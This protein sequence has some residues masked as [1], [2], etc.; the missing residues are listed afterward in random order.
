MLPVISGPQ[1]A[2][3]PKLAL[4]KNKPRTLPGLRFILLEKRLISSEPR[5][6]PRN[7]RS[8]S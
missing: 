6:A 1:R 4:N 8:G 7:R 5:L 2:K 3:S